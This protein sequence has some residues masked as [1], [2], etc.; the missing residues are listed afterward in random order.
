M[1][2]PFPFLPPRPPGRHPAGPQLVPPGAP[3]RAPQAP[4]TEAPVAVASPVP[5]RP[6]SGAFSGRRSPVA[7]GTGP[8]GGPPSRSGLPATPAAL[9]E[10]PRALAAGEA[11]AGRRQASLA[12]RAAACLAW[13]GP[14][15]PSSESGNRGGGPRRWLRC[16][17][18][19]WPGKFS[20]QHPGPTWLLGTLRPGRRESTRSGRDYSSEHFVPSPAPGLPRGWGD[21]QEEGPH[22]AQACPSVVPGKPLPACPGTPPPALPRTVKAGRAVGGTWVRGGGCPARHHRPRRHRREGPVATGLAEASTQHLPQTIPPPGRVLPSGLVSEFGLSRSPNPKSISREA[23]LSSCPGGR[24]GLSSSTKWSASSVLPVARRQ[25]Q[26][27]A[28]Q[29][30]G[31]ALTGELIPSSWMKPERR[32]PPGGQLVRRALAR[33]PPEDQALRA[34][35]RPNQV[36]RVRGKQRS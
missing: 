4:Q 3:G 18:G 23:R 16:R 22:L 32:S 15:A 2:S 11:G 17:E 27:E 31:P 36:P 8:G 24:P 25:L 28:P 13:E 33:L 9:W 10:L 34:S 1:T 29:A 26:Q 20:K 5:C 6:G 35:V 7:E 19:L 30:L 14:A 21:G 12:A